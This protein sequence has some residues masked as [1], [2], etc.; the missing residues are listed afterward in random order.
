[1]K[2][3]VVLVTYNQENYI[4][5]SLESI[6]MQNTSFEFDII[7]ADDCST[8]S[9]LNIIKSYAGTSRI[10]FRLL[11]NSDNIGAE[12]NYRRSFAACDGEYIAIMEGD[13]FWINPRRL[14][15]IVDFLDEY[16]DCSMAFNRIVFYRQ[17]TDDY[18]INKWQT[19]EDYDF[20]TTQQLAVG[21]RIGNLSA[22][23]C[24]KSVLDKLK[25]GLFDISF[26]DWILGMALGEHGH[27]AY[28]KEPMSVYRIHGGGLWSRQ[29][30]KEQIDNIINL[31]RDYNKYLGYRYNDEFT[32]YE[33]YLKRSINKKDKLKK[34]DFIP[35]ALLRALRKK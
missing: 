10:N 24:R 34:S 11:E 22:C 1:M 3:N 28:L 32:R 26:A 5:K 15:T 27:I 8:D 35:P 20:I 14:Q 21:N 13:D 12:K 31:A 7:V 17:D 6:L 23:I 29:N 18:T 2:L 25:P 9:T 19:G 16:Q 33:E 4:R 30:E